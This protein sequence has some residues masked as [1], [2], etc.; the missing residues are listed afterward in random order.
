MDKTIFQKETKIVSPKEG[1]FSL[2][3]LF[4]LTIGLGIFVARKLSQLFEFQGE[5][6]VPISI[7]QF[8][9]EFVLALFIIFLIL[10]FGKKFKQKK[11]TLLK[12]LFLI[13]TGLGS[14]ISLGTIFGDFS[15]PIVLVL[16]FLWL[17]KPCVL[18]HNIL[19]VFGI[20]GTGSYLGLSLNPKSV[21]LLL[22]LFSAYDYIAVYKT[23]HMV[24][25]AKEMLQ[26]GVIIGLIL[27]HNLS[28]YKTPLSQVK[29][30]GERFFVL[31][32]GDI[33]FPLLLCCSILYQGLINSLIVA[34]F[35]LIGFAFSFLIF[36][37]QKTPRPIP[38]LPPIALFSIIGYAIARII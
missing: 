7:W 18:F 29:P 16:L 6:I 30:G 32:G 14:L 11:K 27:P 10:F 13:A 12:V 22:I 3:F 25:M 1:I 24:V 2:F 36:S 37:R 31:G 35:A 23:K 19:V 4:S 38:A 9:G 28:D 20:A 5:K 33:T 8:L 26:E 15:F 17:K 34:G 21:V